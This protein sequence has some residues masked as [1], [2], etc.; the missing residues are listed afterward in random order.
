MS[1]HIVEDGTHPCKAHYWLIEP[2]NG[3]F[4]L[5]VCKHCA[6]RREF[7]N[8]SEADLAME[9]PRGLGLPRPTGDQMHRRPLTLPGSYVIGPDG[10]PRIP[11][12]RQRPMSLRP[13]RAGGK[14]TK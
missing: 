6:H 7:R 12:H 8:V 10:V 14:P 5:G 13:E 4:S 2:P 3:I 1:T 11:R 9:Q